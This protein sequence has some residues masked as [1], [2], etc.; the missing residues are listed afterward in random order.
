MSLEERQQQSELQKL[1]DV[2]ESIQGAI[3]YYS[4]PANSVSRRSPQIK[5][6]RKVRPCLIL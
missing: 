2:I 6:I 1:G 5:S 4:S 3:T